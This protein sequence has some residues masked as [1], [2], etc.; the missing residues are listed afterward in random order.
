MLVFIPSLSFADN[1]V[2]LNK[3]NSIKRHI[4]NKAKTKIAKKQ[5][6]CSYYIQI[7]AFKNEKNA[8]KLQMRSRM[9]F[10]NSHVIKKN[11]FNRVI[12]SNF[13]S[14]S[15]AKEQLKR[16]KKLASDAFIACE[17]VAP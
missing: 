2:S 13:A 6:Y 10:A 1:F 3:K 4:V 9:L 15:D 8:Y 17:R 14:K 11:D 16:A 7:G 5:S 12:I